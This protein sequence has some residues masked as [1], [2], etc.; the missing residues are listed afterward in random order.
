MQSSLSN[1]FNKGNSRAFLCC[2]NVQ[3]KKSERL[4]LGNNLLN[5]NRVLLESSVR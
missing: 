1:L 4:V 2:P 3:R 5:M